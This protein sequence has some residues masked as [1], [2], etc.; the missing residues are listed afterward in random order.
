VDRTGNARGNIIRPSSALPHARHFA[1]KFQ[2]TEIIGTREGSQTH[3]G[4][5]GAFSISR[6]INTSLGI[7]LPGC[8]NLS[9][10]LSLSLSLAQVPSLSSSSSSSGLSLPPTRNASRIDN[11]LDASPSL[12]LSFRSRLSSA[13]IGPPMAPLKGMLRTSI[14]L[15]NPAGFT[16]TSQE[17]M[18]ASH[19]DA[20]MNTPGYI[21][22]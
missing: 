15:A 19:F 14:I 12:P 8:S 3:F 1:S 20:F 21:G 4:W 10:S 11:A 22:G 7:P 17:Q 9:L 6:T 5:P 16:D 13:P 18:N 2:P